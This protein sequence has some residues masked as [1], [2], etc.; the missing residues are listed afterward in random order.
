MKIRKARPKKSQIHIAYISCK[1]AKQRRIFVK[2]A[3][4]RFLVPDLFSHGYEP[5]DS[6]CRFCEKSVLDSIP[7]NSPVKYNET[8]K[9]IC[10]FHLKQ[11][12]TTLK[13]TN[14]TNQISKYYD[15][16]QSKRNSSNDESN[17]TFDFK[18]VKCELVLRI[19][20]LVCEKELEIK[21]PPRKKRKTG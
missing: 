16:K 8:F 9:H 2:L 3:T 15:H 12:N 21:T 1:S 14:N 7:C 17:D 13:T 19:V 4:D 20:D 6:S 18:K 5:L 11:N 10:E